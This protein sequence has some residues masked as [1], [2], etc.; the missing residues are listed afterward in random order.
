MK[1]SLTTLLL[2]LALAWPLQ[3]ASPE[4]GPLEAGNLFAQA[5]TLRSDGRTAEAIVLFRQAAAVKAFPLADYAQFEVGETF[6][7]NGDYASAI[8]EYYRLV[9][10][11]FNSLLQPSANLMLGKAYFNTQT[12]PQAIKT[13][14]HLVDKYAAA[15][16]AAEASFLIARARQEAGDW[17]AAYLAYNETD[18]LFPLTYFG[19]QSRLA[20]A[21]LKKA[22]RKKLPKFQA[23]AAALYRQ[24][25]D[26][27][28]QDDFDMAANIF[29][30]LVREYPKSK[31]VNEAWLMLGRAE[32]Q[33]NKSSAISD[34][35]RA[36]AGPPNLAG[37][38]YFYLGQAYGRRGDYDD[39]IVALLKVTDRYPDSGLASEAAYWIAYYYEQKGNT[40][41]ALGGYYSLIKNYPYSA[42]VSAAIWR[43]GHLYYWNSDFGHAATYFHLAQ[44]YPPGEDTPRCLFFEAKALERTGSRESAVATYQKLIDRYDHT[45]YAYRAQEKVNAYGLTVRN[46]AP[47]NGEDFSL[48]LNE[49]ETPDAANLAA[50]ME[51]W[52]KTHAGLLGDVNSAEAQAHLIKYKELMNLSLTEY[53]ADEARYLVDIT[54]D[55]EK[56]S[57]Q[58]K[59]GEMLVSRGNYR[60]P[61]MFADRRIK[62]AIMAGKQSA[63]PKKIWQ[64]SYPKAY[65]R[66][67]ANQAAKLKTDPYLLLAVMREESRFNPRARSRSSARGLMQIMPKTGR[68]I[69]K[70]LRYSGY[71][72][73]HLY[74]PSV[75]IEM[76][77]YYLT[78]LI[79]RFKNN[80]YLAVASYNGGPNRIKRYV[81][82]WY[83]GNLGSVDID[84][85]VESIP[86]RETRLYVQK[87]MGSYFEYKRLYDRKR[88]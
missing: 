48:A 16:E 42:T 14:R 13:F 78:D 82:N 73:A 27:F 54:S 32:Q 77:S 63:V 87:V 50:I 36:T 23:S 12:F 71:R 21:Q 88:G 18:L 62:A 33:T 35:Q 49:L 5:I 45:Y 72:T 6:Y 74:E 26:Y 55:S 52:E 20:I 57:V 17:R 70:N 79:E 60:T 2:L 34:L 25:M 76:G 4:S 58:T 10:G 61:I 1:H 15:P 41:R 51:I 22:H 44:T 31:Y 86:V 64:L 59:L 80:A 7:A 24:G 81:D 39:A 56:E 28:E 53:A 85:F 3:A 8:P 83:N 66:Q 47:F 40:E 75:N 65:W 30:R 9:T 46:R 11:Y 37:R 68:G 29:S 19:R 43:L 67:A 38:A 69:A 84:E